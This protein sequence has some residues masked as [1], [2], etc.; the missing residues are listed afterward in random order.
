MMRFLPSEE[1]TVFAETID[2]IVQGHGGSEIAQQ[3]AAGESD[4]GLALWT[5]FAELGLTALRVPETQ[6]GFGGSLSD[7]AIVFER[8][9]YHG[10]PGPYIESIAFLPALVD[11]ATRDAIVAG[12]IATVGIDGSVPAAL[13]ASVAA[14][15]FHVQAG[16]LHRATV[17]EEAESLAPTRRLS[18]LARRVRRRA[19][20][21]PRWP[22]HPTRRPSRLRPC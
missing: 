2:E 8:L 18:F 21:R 5:Q 9:G 19:W 3:W 20:T 12:E 14:H 6:G 22:R 13:D 16:G 11:E 1:Q 15:L 10:V 17:R 7:L 4:A